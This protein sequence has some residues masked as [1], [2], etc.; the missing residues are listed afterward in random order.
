MYYI[1]MYY[2]LHVVMNFFVCPLSDT[3]SHPCT[4]LFSVMSTGN[5]RHPRTKD[6]GQPTVLGTYE[7]EE[8][9]LTYL[10]RMSDMYRRVYEI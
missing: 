10:K 1:F 9:I 7:F 8:Y 5:H 2:L 6:L 3:D 4:Y